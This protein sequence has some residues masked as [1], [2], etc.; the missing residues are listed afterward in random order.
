MKGGFSLRNSCD[1][2]GAN[3]CVTQTP[4][5]PND[6]P[7]ALNTSQ[8]LPVQVMS[9]DASRNSALYQNDITEVRVNALFGLSLIRAYE[10]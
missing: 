6:S 3:G 5:S 7:G 8:S 10:V 4:S 1:Y 9:I 2:G